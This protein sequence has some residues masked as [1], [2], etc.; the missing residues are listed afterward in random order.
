MIGQKCEAFCSPKTCC[1]SSSCRDPSRVFLFSVCSYSPSWFRGYAYHRLQTA[2][3]VAV[4]IA[5]TNRNISLQ[6]VVLRAPLSKCIPGSLLSTTHSKPTRTYWMS[7]VCSIFPPS[8]SKKAT[9]VAP[10]TCRG[11]RAQLTAGGRREREEEGRST[12][13]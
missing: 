2:V 5:H 11:H 4:L 1:Q 9:S 8:K 13:C 3:C 12:G 7:A 6:P 10:H